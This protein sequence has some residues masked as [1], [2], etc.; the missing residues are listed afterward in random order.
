[1][2]IT[3]HHFGLHWT[4][5]DVS[6]PA[7]ALILPDDSRCLHIASAGDAETDWNFSNPTHPTVYIHSETTPAT[8]YIAFDHDGTDGTINV[9]SG[10]LKL[11]LDG[12]DEL[13]LTGAALSPTTSDGTALGTAVLM[14]ADLFLASGAVIN[15]NGGDVTITHSANTLAIAGATSGYLFDAAITSSNATAGI[16]YATGAGGAVT[17]LTNKATG[18]TTNTV[19]GTITMN[20]V[21]LAADTTVSFTLTN[22]AIAATDAV[23]VLHESAGTLGAYSFASTAAAGSAV[24]AVHNNTPGALGEAIVLRFVVIKSVNA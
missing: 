16:G 17:Q 13:T 9:A 20:N 22:S 3:Q 12:T 8:D 15:F 23:I 19:T 6:L 14:W 18:V 7:G 24:I 4:V 11:A 1:M 21:S 10:N 2:A 5:G